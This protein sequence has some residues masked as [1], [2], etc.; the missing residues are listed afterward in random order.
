MP[1]ITLPIP[2][3]E[4]LAALSQ[5]SAQGR[6]IRE[7]L[8]RTALSDKLRQVSPLAVSIGSQHP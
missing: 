6:E 2:A 3:H 7:D 8:L 4:L 5:A 1:T